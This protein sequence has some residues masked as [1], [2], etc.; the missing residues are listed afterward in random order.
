[1]W[2]WQAEYAMLKEKY[3]DPRPDLF[4]PQV[5]TFDNYLWAFINIF[6]RA[7]RVSQSVRRAGRLP[8]VCHARGAGGREAVGDAACCCCFCWWAVYR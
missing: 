7:I 3:M 1:M 2:G 8:D 5:Y 4:D 6:S